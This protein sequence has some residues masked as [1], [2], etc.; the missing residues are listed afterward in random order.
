MKLLVNIN[1]NV[2]KT[3]I[4]E[5]NGKRTIEKDITVSECIKAIY[6]LR[7]ITIV[8]T[9]SGEHYKIVL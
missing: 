1:Y 3:L 5:Y 8:N 7:E 9:I 6:L 2:S 4:V